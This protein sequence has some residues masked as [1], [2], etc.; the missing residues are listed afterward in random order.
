MA[1]H[2]RRNWRRRWTVD[3]VA[4]QARHDS[5]AVVRF[6]H[7]QDSVSGAPGD[8]SGLAPRHA[9]IDRPALLERLTR[10]HGQAAAVQMLQ[11]IER[12]AVD[13]YVSSAETI[14]S[15]AQ[16]RQQRRRARL[17]R[18]GGRQVATML[19][20]DAAAALDRLAQAFGS[21]RA[22]I[23]AAIIAGDRARLKPSGNRKTT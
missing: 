10:E 17:E 13:V 9:V 5:G 15:Q 23:E 18:A 21:A 22:A 12:E 3:L 8:P 11:R 7:G 1:N 19:S 6:E 2:P 14:R 20:A 16:A 4:L